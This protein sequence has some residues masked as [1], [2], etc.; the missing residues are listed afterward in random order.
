MWFGAGVDEEPEKR[1]LYS[2]QMIGNRAMRRLGDAIAAG[3]KLTE[4][5]A[6]LWGQFTTDATE[7]TSACTTAVAT[8]FQLDP[9][10]EVL[11]R[12][13]AANVTGRPKTRKTLAE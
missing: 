4:D 3:R 6:R 9:I 2:P 10:G 8:L 5:E 12:I 11:P 7:R 1:H 13:A